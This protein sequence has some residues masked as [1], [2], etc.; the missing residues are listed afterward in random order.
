[1][2]SKV[3]IL[4]RIGSDGADLR[5]TPKGV[6]VA[7]FSLAADNGYGEY[8]ATIWYR[9]TAW[10]KTAEFA[11]EYLSKGMAILVDGELKPDPETGAPRM[12][13]D[14][15][16][17]TKTSYEITVNTI[18]FAERKPDTVETKVEVGEMPF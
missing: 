16:G 8:K 2:Y 12:W 9:C 3:I 15:N 11:A 5:Y 10:N 1:M 4:G 17:N 13:Q 7:T 6:P 18:K 14:N